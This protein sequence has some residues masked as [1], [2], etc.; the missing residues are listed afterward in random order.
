MCLTVF[1]KDEISSAERYEL[2]KPKVADKPI[3]VY[4][5]LRKNPTGSYQ[6]PYQ[7]TDVRF[8]FWRAKMESLGMGG[9]AM[10]QVG[11]GYLFWNRRCKTWHAQHDGKVE[12][13]DLYYDDMDIS[14]KRIEHEGLIPFV[15]SV[16]TGIHAFVD[17]PSK[18]FFY[19]WFN[20][21]RNTT[22]GGSELVVFKATIPKGTRYYLGLNGDIV[23]EKM[24]VHNRKVMTARK[25]DYVFQTD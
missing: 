3:R 10:F 11:N 19:T 21:T 1:N 24:I 22:I 12:F 6:T 4:K 16:A 23:A 9:N 8:H 13:M 15:F 2:M 18:A 7:G 5:V 17:V 20:T 25:S 14:S